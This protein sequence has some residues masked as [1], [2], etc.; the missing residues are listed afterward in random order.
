MWLIIFYSVCLV[1][2]ILAVKTY[3][4]ELSNPK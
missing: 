2:W 1:L 4:H 3:I